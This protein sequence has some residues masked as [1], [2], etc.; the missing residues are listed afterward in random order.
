MERC[1]KIHEFLQ[2]D[3]L[4]LA[5]GILVA[6]RKISNMADPWPEQLVAMTGNRLKYP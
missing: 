3:R 5:C 4:T 2:Y 1:L 6:A